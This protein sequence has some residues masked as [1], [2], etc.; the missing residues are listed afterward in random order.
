MP[1]Q[2]V[3]ARHCSHRTTWTTYDVKLLRTEGTFD[4]LPH[5]YCSCISISDIVVAVDIQLAAEFVGVRSRHI[6]RF[7]IQTA[8]EWGWGSNQKR[9]I[10][11]RVCIVMTLS[12]FTRK[13]FAAQVIVLDGIARRLNV[14]SQDAPGGN[15]N[16]TNVPGAIK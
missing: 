9:H 11:C 16:T 12:H 10:S 6:S 3:K 15:A 7:A 5:M 4:K 14:Y 8:G 2:P 13:C 1:D